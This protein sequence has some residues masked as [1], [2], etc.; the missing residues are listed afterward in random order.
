MQAVAHITSLVFAIDCCDSALPYEFSDG[1]T[2]KYRSIYSP[3]MRSQFTTKTRF[4]PIRVFIFRILCVVYAY[5]VLAL[6]RQS[7]YL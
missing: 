1:I 6:K 7:K 3:F 5:T 4:V 2:R